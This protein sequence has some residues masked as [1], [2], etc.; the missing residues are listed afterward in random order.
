MNPL[1]IPSW[2]KKK[3]E[4]EDLRRTPHFIGV[5]NEAVRDDSG[6]KKHVTIEVRGVKGNSNSSF[7]LAHTPGMKLS[8]YLSRLKLKRAATYAAVYD[9]TNLENGRCR[10]S[11]I[12][13]PGSHIVIGSPAAGSATHLQRTSHDATRIMARMGRKKDGTYEKVIEAKK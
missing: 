12:P 2:G 13:R 9:I 1:D 10:M 4:V 8:R 6:A 5:Q 3:K 7:P 11:Y